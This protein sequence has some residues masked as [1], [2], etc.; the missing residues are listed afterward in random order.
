MFSIRIFLSFLT[1]S[2]LSLATT[3]SPKSFHVVIDPGHGGAEQG[4][5]RD[6]FIESK[7]VLKIAEKVKNRLHLKAPK[8]QVTL[9]RVE[10]ISMSLKDR[11]DMANK[12]QAD[13]FVSL[14][15]NS[16]SQQFLSGMEFYFNSTSPRRLQTDTTSA[17]NLPTPEEVVEKIKND[18]SFYA[19]TER[20]LLLSKTFK[21]QTLLPDQ[22]SVIKRAPFY[23]VDQTEM[24]S[25]LVEL[26]FI[27]NR[28]EAKKLSSEEYQEEIARL[29]SLAI[30]DYK[31][32]SDK[33]Q[34]L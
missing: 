13:L 3:L 19:K 20:S 10:D 2:T 29:L 31:E 27:S 15:A 18:F 11:V 22:K 25:V 5:V 6:S 24:P 12:L 8:V 7:I 16:A 34:S 32:K 21:E 23:V 17:K 26:G 33:S 30:L 1:Y 9:T 28:R 14:H 4:A